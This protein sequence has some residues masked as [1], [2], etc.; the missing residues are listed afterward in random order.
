M[1]KTI[2]VVL[3]GL[4]PAAFAG[5]YEDAYPLGYDSN[6][7]FIQEGST[8]R[9]KTLVREFVPPRL[10]TQAVRDRY[11]KGLVD[12]AACPDAAVPDDATLRRSKD[13]KRVLIDVV[14]ESR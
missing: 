6:P 7:W 1:K 4:A 5:E 3:V 8:D 9:R 11:A 12:A 13:G 14:C 10:W 2:G